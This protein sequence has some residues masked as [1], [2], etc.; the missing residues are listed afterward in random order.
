MPQPLRYSLRS[1]T[2][3]ITFTPTKGFFL[4]TEADKGFSALFT[5]QLVGLT[6]AVLIPPSVTTLIT[7]ENFPFCTFTLSKQSAAV[8]TMT[9]LWLLVSAMYRTV[10]PP[11]RSDGIWRS[12]D[13]LCDSIISFSTFAQCT[14]SA[15]LFFCQLHRLS[16]SFL[17]VFGAVSALWAAF[18]RIPSAC[19]TLTVTAFPACL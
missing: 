15:F 1:A 8:L 12:P 16:A 2:E 17:A 14:D 4:V 19:T 5:D 13:G 11:E 10:P 18:M 9:G 6:T 3:V 7:A